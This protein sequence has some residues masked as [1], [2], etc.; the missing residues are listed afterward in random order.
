MTQS[1]Q[2]P[3]RW[4]AEPCPQTS[5]RGSLIEGYLEQVDEKRRCGSLQFGG[6][7][8]VATDTP[9]IVV[10]RLER[11]FGQTVALAG[12]SFQVAAGE[13]VGL[14]G[15]NGAGKTTTIRLVLGLLAPHGGTVRVFGFEP[16]VDGERIRQRTGVVGESPG[17]DERL[18][19]RELLQVFADLY[20]VP[21]AV[22]AQRIAALL[23][24]FGLAEVA[25]RRV[26][27]YSAGM[28]QRLALARCLLHDPELLLLDEPTATL[29]P[30]AAHHVR[31]LIAERRREGRTI[32]LATHNLDEA[33]RLCDRVVIL[34]RGRVLVEG[35]PQELAAA[36]GVPAQLAVE[37]E[38]E[39]M[40]IAIDVLTRRNLAAWA[41][42]EPGRI[43]VERMTRRQVPDVVAALVGAGVPVYGVMLRTPSLED[44]YLALHQRTERR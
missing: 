25:D 27:T 33:E 29:D 10:D 17:L 18:T 43:I 13:I 12:I 5:G 28:R 22:Q 42:P 2:L 9:V 16:M 30:V 39:L 23:E 38:P 40:D 20:D 24:Q 31:E 8:P 7:D 19:A 26:A 36:L 6:I 21:R 15:H 41:E 34:E 4:S 14:L 44:V 11:R 3:Q 35:H 1:S 32:L 37:V